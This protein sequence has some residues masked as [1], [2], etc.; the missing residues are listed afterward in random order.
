L[1]KVKFYSNK[2][3]IMKRLIFCTLA[4]CSVLIFSCEKKKVEEPENDEENKTFN[5]PEDYFSIQSA[6]N[7]SVDG[8]TIFVQPGIY[9]ENINFIGKK[10][11]V[12]S[13]DP[14]DT[15]VVGTTI[16][17]GNTQGTVVT[18]D[19]GETNS[20]VLNGF[21][22]IN[23]DAGTSNGGGVLIKNNS[24]PVIKNSVFISN[25]AKYGAGICVSGQSQPKIEGNIF[26]ANV[27]NGSRGTAIYVMDESSVIIDSNI[28]K[29]H[30]N[31][32]GVIHIG[33]TYT[34][35]SS[36]VISN[37]TINNNTTEFGTGA[38]K[39]TAAS[40]AEISNNTIT[41]NT[42]SGDYSACG[43]TISKKSQANI[44]N[45]TITDN[46]AKQNGAILI[47]DESEAVIT[48]N[49]IS[50]NSAGSASDTR[51]G[52]GGAISVTYS[53]IADI[54][55]NTISENYAWNLNH[56]GGGIIISYSSTAT[57]DNNQIFDNN[58]YRFGGGVYVR[59]N[60]NY[61]TITNN[62]ISG[63]NAD[64]YG[65]SDG[66]GVYLR[67]IVKAVVHNNDIKNNWA[68]RF[69]GGIYVYNN[70]DVLE[71]E[72]EELWIRNNYPPVENFYNV[73]N[74]N[75]HGDNTNEGADVYFSD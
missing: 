40:T 65:A 70:V 69:C 67:N 68:Q 41:N 71:C 57:I 20:S 62:V 66:G 29:N 35:E 43:I 56:G 5:V 26:N 2:K 25:T 44:S 42:G 16:I 14:N 4:F 13:T 22:I 21:T 72:S 33:S 1:T 23:G 38:I 61:V 49:T 59:F 39:V 63:N 34:D 50:G 32:D 10:V 52:T 48:G 24:S 11:I 19:N 7:A 17:D 46:A 51:Y 55:N 6:I 18:F 54:S 27:A 8:S 36:A 60:S 9:Q 74:N 58:A 3:K 45:N 15:G 64:G 47:Y 31:V 28:F 12:C 73:Y 37:N 53:S 75:T 30:L